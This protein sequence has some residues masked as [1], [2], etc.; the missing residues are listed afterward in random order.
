MRQLVYVQGLIRSFTNY[1]S[2]VPD[3]NVEIGLM[4]VEVQIEI[5]MNLPHASFIFGDPLPH[6]HY[7]ERIQELRILQGEIMDTIK[8]LETYLN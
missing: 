4:P 3:G 5:Y 6:S 8:I 7:V 2:T 1:I